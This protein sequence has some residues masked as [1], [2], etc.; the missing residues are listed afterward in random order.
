MDSGS[1]HRQVTSSRGGARSHRHSPRGHRHTATLSQALLSRLCHRRGCQGL[2][3]LCPVSLP[4][5]VFSDT[6][7]DAT[8][9]GRRRPRY[10]QR[11]GG[12]LRPRTER[13]LLK[14]SAATPGLRG[15]LP[16][17]EVA[18]GL[19]RIFPLPALVPGVGL[20]SPEESGGF[21][22]GSSIG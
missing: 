17:Q 14:Q 12:H 20:Q 2:G 9:A 15:L 21:W 6:A 4:W 3:G 16:G 19:S 1:H 13:E 10:L 11:P 7:P 8:A 22:L 5:H 18:K